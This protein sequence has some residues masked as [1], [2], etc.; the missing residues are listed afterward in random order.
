MSRFYAH[1]MIAAAEVADNLL[2]IGN[3][4]ATESQA[5]PLTALEPEQQREAWQRL[6][7]I[8]M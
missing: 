8:W 5:R 6:A 4:P 2:P 7:A 3:I 1:R